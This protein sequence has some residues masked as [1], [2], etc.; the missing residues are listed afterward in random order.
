MKIARQNTQLSFDTN[1][2]ELV[3]GISISWSSFR[4]N[5]NEF[6]AFQLKIEFLWFHW[7]KVCHSKVLANV[8]MVIWR[9]SCMIRSFLV[10]SSDIPGLLGLFVVL[11]KWLKSI[12]NEKNHYFRFICTCKFYINQKHWE[13]PPVSINLSTRSW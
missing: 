10:H 7:G 13:S 5:E 6:V 12:K 8:L 3:I 9:R 1:L 11:R 2:S 4:D